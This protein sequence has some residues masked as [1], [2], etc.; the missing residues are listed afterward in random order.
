VTESSKRQ[1]VS[2]EVPRDQSDAARASY[3]RCCASPDFIP[4]FYHLFFTACP[5]AEP[6]FAETDFFRQHQLLRHALRLLLLYPNRP[7]A[8]GHDLLRRVAERHSRRDLDI[9][10]SLYPPFVE[11]LMETV[12]RFDPQWSPEIEAA[13][14][15]TI[16]GGVDYMIA[17]Y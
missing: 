6:R 17:R 10:A 8:E 9:P 16:K 12:A 3:D 13:W 7:E 2:A 11:S 14:R 5:A 15:S 4:T 1:R